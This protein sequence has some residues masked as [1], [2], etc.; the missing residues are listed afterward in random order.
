[1]V[2]WD[3]GE[4]PFVQVDE[5]AG[6]AA[7]I[8][9]DGVGEFVPECAVE[10]A[11]R[12]A[13]IATDI[14]DDRTD[15][16]ATHLGGDFLLGGEA[17][18]TRVL[19]LDGGLGFGGRGRGLPWRVWAACDGCAEGR[20]GE[21][22]AAR[23]ALGQCGLEAAAR[24]RPLMMRARMVAMSAVP[25]GSARRAKSGVAARCWTVAA[26]CLPKSMSF[27]TRVRTR[28]MRLGVSG[29]ARGGSG[30]VGAGSWASADMNE[31][32]T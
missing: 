13:E 5:E 30:D 2:V 4:Q 10:V 17:G 9:D 29:A 18:E 15:G 26:S 11:W 31:T 19:S 23:G 1:M 20:W 7:A 25:K 21:V 32:R 16:A 27:R 3:A 28:P 14:D 6:E 22:L 12:D 24:R 8:G